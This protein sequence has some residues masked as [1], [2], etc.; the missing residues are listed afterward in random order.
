MKC[1]KCGGAGTFERKGTTFMCAPRYVCSKCGWMRLG[2]MS[3]GYRVGCFLVMLWGV[4]AA[5]V[6]LRDGFQPEE[7]LALVLQCGLGV[8]AAVALLTPA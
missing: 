5:Y 6:H 3:S 2:Q 1:Q 7:T 4:W 8:F